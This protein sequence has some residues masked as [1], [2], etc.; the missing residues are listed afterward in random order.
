V[1]QQQVLHAASGASKNKSKKVCA[2]Q[3]RLNTLATRFKDAEIDTLEYLQGLSLLVAK[4]VKSK[5]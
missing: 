5:K 2:M 4:D 3:D 1:F